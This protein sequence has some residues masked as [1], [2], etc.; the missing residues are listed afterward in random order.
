VA[1]Q[2]ILARRDG[3]EEGGALLLSDAVAGLAGFSANPAAWPIFGV[4][5]GHQALALAR[6]GENDE[7]R[8]ALQGW[9]E[10]VEACLDAP[11]RTELNA[12]LKS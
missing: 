2:G 1:I 4:L 5:V 10:V 3:D 7:A 9:E 6:S 8:E 12:A 11:T